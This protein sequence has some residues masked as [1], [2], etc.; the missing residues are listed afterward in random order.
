MA[1]KRR[2]VVAGGAAL[3]VAAAPTIL[4]AQPKVHVSHGMAMH[5][6]PKYPADAAT[7][8]YVNPNAPKGGIARFGAPL[9]STFDSLHPFIIK[10]VP[11]AGIDTLWETLCWPARDE[12]FTVYGMIAE[13]IE[14]PEDRMWVA[15]T[16][17]PQARWQDGTP[18]TVEDVVWSFDTLKSKGS[19]RYAT[20]Y[21]D[22]V[23]AEKSGDRKVLF[24][25]R[26]NVNRELPLILGSLPVLPSKWWAG[27]D[28]EKVSLEPALAS[29]PYTIDSVDVGRSI[30]YRRVP[31]WWAKDLWMNRGRNNFETVRYD[32][33]R[34]GNIAFEAFKAGDLDIRREN[35]GRN[36]KTKYDDV[37]AV[38]DGR[39]KK[40][41]LA[42]ENATPMQG[43]VFNLRRNL[44]KDRRVR[45]AISL[46]Y[47]F[48][49]QNKNLSYGFY[50]RTR[51]F[52]GNCELEAKGLPSPEE[53]KILEPLR[54]KIPDEVFTTEWNPPKT[55]GSGNIREQARKAIA[56]LKEA[57]WEI[58]D[59]KMTDKEGRKFAFE[60]ILPELGFRG[61][62]AAG[63]A[64]LRA[65]RHRHERTHHR[66]LAVPAA[67]RHL[68]FRHGDRPVGAGAVARQRAARVLGFEGRRHPG[69][70][71]QHGL[72]GPGGRPADRADHR[73]ARPREPD[74]A[75][76]LPRPRA[77]V[78]RVHHPAVLFGQ[79]AGRLLEPLHATRE[80]REVR[81]AGVRHLV[82]RRGQ[83]QEPAARRKE[84][85]S[86]AR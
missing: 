80:D 33:Y 82:G 13:T 36:W 48:E 59:G 4:R 8:D 46:M 57:G 64:E 62:D 60:I 19:P 61:A 34:D 23:K 68:R 7:P 1:I 41:E 27:K 49:W 75:H 79:G 38:K 35:S 17:R 26:G 78:A 39:I 14:W 71:E 85:V 2:T 16:L 28:F 32:Y 51:S 86:G 56:L 77:A 69:R 20:Y 55:D 3:W 84:D 42:H 11:A 31:D 83:G 18:I 29:G 63:E 22:V 53:L 58:K 43:F 52:F 44:F 65:H 24:S 66:H 6:E 76:A 9:T 74:R 40:E 25:F 72:E 45:E 73:R 67:H 30:T 5:G 37:P 54:G 70:Q 10:G 47:D 81:S 12:A 21:A 15:F 50:Q